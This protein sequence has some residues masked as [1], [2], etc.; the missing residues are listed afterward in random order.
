MIT[1]I[2]YSADKLSQWD[3]FVEQSKNGIFMFKRA[4]MEYHADRFQDASLL[5][6]G[7]KDEL[8]AL[9]PATRHEDEIR[10]H[11]GLTYGGFIVGQEMKQAK[12]LACFDAL[13]NYMREAGIKK[14]VYKCIPHI[15]HRA[16]AEEELYALFRNNARL[17]KTEP[18][19][20]TDLQRPY[21]LPKGRKAQIARAKREG[22]TIRETLDFDAFIALE[23]EVLSKHHNASAVHTGAE[24]TLLQSRFP[25][26]IKS[27]CAY[28]KD[29]HL[30]SGCVLF[31]YDNTVHT[32]YL[33]ANDYARANGGLDYVISEVMNVY[34]TTHRYF[35]FGISTEEMGA[36]LNE[37]LIAQKEGFGGR[38]IAYTT[39]E[40]DAGDRE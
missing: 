38:T 28:D 26:Q 1:V 4:F 32:Q 3:A 23:N 22:I 35:D 29:D 11:G 8:I 18:A 19:S 34:R 21:K 36:V 20:V 15:F 6:Y 16:P 25:E 17:L 37:G 24:L 9:F 2:P 27:V 33:A 40:F 13:R 30:C 7:E 10:S 14:C 12:M 5:F 31:I 39:W